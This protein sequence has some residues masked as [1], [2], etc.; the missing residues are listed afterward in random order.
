M[1]DILKRFQ[2]IIVVA[3]LLIPLFGIGQ[4]K[5]AFKPI[6]KWNIKAQIWMRY[7]ELNDGSLVNSESTSNYS[8]VSIRRIRMP[9]SA[10]VTP[11][12]FMYAIIG[13]NNYNIKEDKMPLNILDLYGEYT[14]GKYLSIG[15]GKSGWQG[16]NRWNIQ[17]SSTLMGLDAP[18]FSLN[19]VEIMMI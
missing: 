10:Q 6:I 16:L 18:L 17:S 9:I 15:L 2:K 12:V 3:L 1:K 7:A 13:G 19:T 14:F 8:D 5:E 4:E 11:Q